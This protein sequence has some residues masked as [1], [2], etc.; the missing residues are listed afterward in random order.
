MFLIIGPSNNEDGE[1]NVEDDLHD[2]EDPK[3]VE[4]EESEEEV[5]LSLN[6]ICK[7]LKPSTIQL[8]TCIRRFEVSLL[9]DSGSTYN[10][11]NANIVEKLGLKGVAVKS[12]EVKVANKDNLKCREMV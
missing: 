7:A 12:L 9:I 10:F 2:K 4:L 3:M 8:M 11:I 6:T 5:K 1:D